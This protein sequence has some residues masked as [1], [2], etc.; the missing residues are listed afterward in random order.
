[1]ETILRHNPTVVTLD[2]G[3]PDIDGVEVIRQLRLFSDAYIVMLTARAEELDTLMGLETVSTSS[4]PS[5]RANCGHASPPCCP[6]P[7]PARTATP[8][9]ARRRRH[10]LPP[11]AYR[12]R[13]HLTL[14]RCRPLTPPEPSRCRRRAT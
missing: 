10:R 11:R 12:Q 6:A 7:A 2:P 14:W 13:P 5:A 8:P 4:D 3:L 1:M 9:R